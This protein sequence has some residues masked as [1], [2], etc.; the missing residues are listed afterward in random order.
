[1]TER[2]YVRSAG[3]GPDDDADSFAV[4]D[5]ATG[6]PIIICGGGRMSDHARSRREAEDI[7]DDLNRHLAAWREIAAT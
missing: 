4:I 7:A 5:S 1:M 2:Y 3:G 6:R